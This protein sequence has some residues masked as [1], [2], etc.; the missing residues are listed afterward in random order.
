M[1]H[2]MLSRAVARM[3]GTD[4]GLTLYEVAQRCSPQQFASLLEP[5]PIRELFLEELLTLEQDGDILPLP[6]V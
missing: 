1:I 4:V 6:N 3:P 5:S 2:A